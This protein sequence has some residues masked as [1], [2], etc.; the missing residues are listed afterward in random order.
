MLGKQ[1]TASELP[2][3]HCIQLMEPASDFLGSGFVG[4]DALLPCGVGGGVGQREREMGRKIDFP[5]GNRKIESAPW[6]CP[7]FSSRN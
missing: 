4:S 7:L 1:G 2:H 6:S 3:T 5:G